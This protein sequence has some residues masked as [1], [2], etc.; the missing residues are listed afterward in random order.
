MVTIPLSVC[1]NLTS[2]EWSCALWP[3]YFTQHCGF[4]SICVIACEN[5]PFQTQQCSVLCIR[6]IFFIYSSSDGHLGSF[7]FLV[8]V[9]TME[10]SSASTSVEFCILYSQ[11]KVPK[12]KI[13]RLY[14]HCIFIVIKILSCVAATFLQAVYQ[15]PISDVLALTCNNCLPHC[16]VLLHCALL[17][18]TQTFLSPALPCSARL[19]FY[20]LPA[21]NSC[22]ILDGVTVYKHSPWIYELGCSGQ[23]LS[24]Q[25]HCIFFHKVSAYINVPEVHC[26]NNFGTSKELF[27]LLL[28]FVCFS[29]L[30]S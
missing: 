6:H 20:L 28:L 11:I 7:H 17:C 23:K 21:P 8:T 16:G 27:V 29:A 12:S 18:I 3:T 22:W 26:F 19:F 9:N 24:C 13:T 5:N 25:E 30:P 4:W 10:N 2:L 15:V 14:N 1:V